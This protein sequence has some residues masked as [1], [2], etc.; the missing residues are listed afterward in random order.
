[1]P[2]I[3]PHHPPQG[4]VC[5]VC[6]RDA[7][8]MSV[9]HY[10][11]TCGE[12]SRPFRDFVLAEA[13]PVG[14]IRDSHRVK[15]ILNRIW[16]SIQRPRLEFT[17]ESL[18]LRPK[19]FNGIQIRTIRWKI[20]VS[21]LRAVQQIFYCLCMVRLHIIHYENRI[22]VISLFLKSQSTLCCI[23]E[24]CYKLFHVTFLSGAPPMPH[25]GLRLIFCPFCSFP[26]CFLTH[27]P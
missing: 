3:S 14:T 4:N 23:I 25:P 12:W 13:E 19:F 16:K 1:M 26:R 8:F 5:T 21:N 10:K 24:N 7:C 20:D 17:K 22:S 6:A 27:S 11:P 18:H 9:T 15:S 2:S